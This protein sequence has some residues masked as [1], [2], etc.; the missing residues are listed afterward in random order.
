MVDP[1]CVR[2]YADA[3]GL[4][5]SYVC[6]DVETSGLDVEHDY[7]LQLGW[8]CVTK[9]Q[10]IENAGI[11][12]N[13]VSELD[14]TKASLLSQRLSST[15]VNMQKRGMAYNWSLNRLQ[16]GVEPK[17]AAER[18][19]GI[20][21]KSEYILA[22][23][24]TLFDFEIIDRLTRKYLDIGLTNAGGN[25]IDTAVI[26]KAASDQL[27]PRAHETYQSFVTRVLAHRGRSKFSMTACIAELNLASQGVVDRRAH[28]AIYDSWLVFLVFETFRAMAQGQP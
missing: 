19:V 15:A 22:H 23:Y 4:P 9:R 14:D 13:H 10:P 1:G 18:I 16:T 25:L 28:D 12:I 24:G 26:F 2:A 21:N 7:I 8:C 3:Y 5:E 20:C 11:I 27:R 17:A 6:V